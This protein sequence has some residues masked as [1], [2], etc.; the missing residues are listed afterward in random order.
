MVIPIKNLRPVDYRVPQS[1]FRVRSNVATGASS[2]GSESKSR[3]NSGL[4]KISD[5]D[6]TKR[7]RR[8][9]AA[10]KR[11]NER[12]SQQLQEVAI[13]GLFLF[14]F[15]VSIPNQNGK[16]PSLAS[17]YLFSS[18]LCRYL[19]KCKYVISSL[20]YFIFI[21]SIQIQK[22]FKWPFLA[23]FYSFHRLYKGTKS[24]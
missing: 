14:I 11:G 4:T 7:E 15:F 10:K 3:I 24:V 22:V 16:W 19:T 9:K 1:D 5:S 20:F 18:S 17:F 21:V 13:S 12:G 23:S 2:S 6:L 8:N